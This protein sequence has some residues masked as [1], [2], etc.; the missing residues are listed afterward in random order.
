MI[1]EGC[2]YCFM[3]V[4][5]HSVSQSRI[6]GLTFDAGVFTN[7][8]HDHLDYHKNFNNYIKAKKLFFD[9]LPKSSFALINNDDSNSIKITQG[10]K[11]QK[12]TYSLDKDSDYKCKIIEHDFDGMLLNIDK[13]DV[14]VRLVGR[15]NA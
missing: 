14:W 7:I 1:E 6:T 12:V 11:A 9:L 10:I 2:E 8:S 5:S 13:T 3:E 15:F 4:S